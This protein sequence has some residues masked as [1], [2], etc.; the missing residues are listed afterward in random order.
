MSFVLSGSLIQRRTYEFRPLQYN[1]V[2]GIGN[3]IQGL[4]DLCY[5]SNG[6]LD[7]TRVY[8]RFKVVSG[9]VKI[10]LYAFSSSDIEISYNNST[11]FGLHGAVRYGKNLNTTMAP[12]DVYERSNWLFPGNLV[13][14]NRVGE[15]MPY[16]ESIT[17]PIKTGFTTFRKCFGDLYNM[18][19]VLGLSVKGPTP[20]DISIF[21]NDFDLTLQM[22]WLFN[23]E[24]EGSAMTTLDWVPCMLFA[25]D[26]KQGVPV[27]SVLW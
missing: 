18:L 13:R 15:N 21:D 27:R 8:N 7:A 6:F 23:C 26:R 5:S 16:N 22:D 10:T 3:Y 20:N 9:H 14:I 25:L 4:R 19:I 17:I 11:L 1:T 2:Y 12:N 24:G